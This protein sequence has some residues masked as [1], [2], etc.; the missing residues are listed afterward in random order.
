MLTN[1]S[2]E[3]AVTDNLGR[4]PRLPESLELAVS[5]DDGFITCQHG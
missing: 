1:T 5:A 3:D 2:L 4:N